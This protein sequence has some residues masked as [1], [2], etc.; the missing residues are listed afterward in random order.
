[1]S[2][3]PGGSLGAFGLS[4]SNPANDFLIGGW[5]S[6]HGYRFQA[7]LFQVKQMLGCSAVAGGASN[8]HPLGVVRFHSQ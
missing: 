2:A 8:S 3:T 5:V 6:N 4:F 1:M 7:E